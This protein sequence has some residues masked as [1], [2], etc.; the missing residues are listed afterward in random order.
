MLSK[1]LRTIALECSSNTEDR[2]WLTEAPHIKYSITKQLSAKGFKILNSCKPIWHHKKYQTMQNKTLRHEEVSVHAGDHTSSS[3]SLALLNTSMHESVQLF[4]SKSTVFSCHAR[5]WCIY[6]YYTSW[7]HLY[8]IQKSNMFTS[9]SVPAVLL[10]FLV[11]VKS[12]IF[13]RP[14]HSSDCLTSW[15]K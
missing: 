15:L 14:L 3:S 4:R 1:S 7:H 6:I 11:L 2:L 10:L 12:F 8:H 9:T 5:Q 13:I